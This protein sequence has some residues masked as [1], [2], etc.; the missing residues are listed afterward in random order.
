MNENGWGGCKRVT[1]AISC[2]YYCITRN[3]RGYRNRPRT[4]LKFDKLDTVLGNENDDALQF[5]IFIPPD[6]VKLLQL[7]FPLTS[8]AFDELLVDLL[9]HIHE[10][11]VSNRNPKFTV[12][13]GPIKKSII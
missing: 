8:R 12:I 11:K 10:F 9:I 1:K 2:G 13:Q 3:N 7:I 6:E 4:H 5:I